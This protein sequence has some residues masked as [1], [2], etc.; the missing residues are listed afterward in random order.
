MSPLHFK[1]S[2]TLTPTA[3]GGRRRPMG[4]THMFLC[5]IGGTFRG[6][7]VFCDA[8]FMVDGGRGLAPGEE[9]VARVDPLSPEL[10]EHVRPGMRFTVHDRRPAVGSGVVLERLEPLLQ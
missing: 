3:E 10:W 6:Q 7:P 5:D 1:V 8:R 2:L 9:G 4:R